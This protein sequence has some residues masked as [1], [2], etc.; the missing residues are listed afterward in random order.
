M[1]NNTFELDGKVVIN[2][3]PIDARQLALVDLKVLQRLT[4]MLG[5]SSFDKIRHELRTN[6]MEATN[7]EQLV[8]ITEDFTAFHKS[9][10]LIS[11]YEKQTIEETSMTD[12]DGD[13]WSRDS[14]PC[15]SSIEE[16]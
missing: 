15:K 11:V 9:V 4:K 13:V 3:S 5:T 1:E 2:F 12:S 10:N 14:K 6:I 16:L 7:L 8:T